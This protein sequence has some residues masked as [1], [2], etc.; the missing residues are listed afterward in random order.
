MKNAAR[1][2]VAAASVSAGCIGGGPPESTPDGP[3][4]I[5]SYPWGIS[6]CA[7]VIAVAQ[8]DAAALQERLPTGFAPRRIDAGGLAEIHFDAYAC[9]E[10]QWL[11]GERLAPLS[12]GSVYVPVEAPAAL[13][14]DGYEAYF[15]KF[16]FLLP[17]AG[18]R[19][20]LEAAG[21]PARDGEARVSATP[22][23]AAGVAVDA[24]L[25]LVP[26]VGFAF[27]GAAGPPEGQDV[28]L[29]FVEYTPL[30][31]GGL[32]RWHAR[33]HDATTSLGTGVLEVRGWPADVLGAP[34]VP[35]TFATG[36]WNL[37]EADVAFP[38]PWP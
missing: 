32:A 2:L 3:T 31:G 30:S 37:D 33:L 35:A 26:D 28:P 23:G 21:L 4:T 7:Y 12:Y 15:V 25:S 18:R 38:I 1:L 17:D 29:P 6:D 20:R 8:A 10:G 19:D 34:T 11:D 9:A 16:D 27:R 14:E 22:A 13:R 24:A 36:R 5:A